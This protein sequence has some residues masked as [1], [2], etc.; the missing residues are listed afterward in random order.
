MLC[1]SATVVYSTIIMFSLVVIIDAGEGTFGVVMQAKAE[2]I[3]K[4]AP[5]RNIVAV[6][7]PRGIY[8]YTCIIVHWVWPRHHQLA[9]KQKKINEPLFHNNNNKIMLFG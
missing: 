2:D 1:D 3:V 8:M 7:T 5:H 6:K 4:S 9:P